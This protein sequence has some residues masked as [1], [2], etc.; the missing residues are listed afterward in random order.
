[1]IVP[2]NE[3]NNGVRRTAVARKRNATPQSAT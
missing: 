1:V 3:S 2:G